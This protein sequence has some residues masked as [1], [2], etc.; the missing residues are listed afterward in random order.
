MELTYS[1]LNGEYLNWSLIN[2]D[3]RNKIDGLRF[4]QHIDNV[5]DVPHSWMVLIFYIH[6]CERVYSELLKRLYELEYEK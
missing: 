2:G 4:A 5:Y 6:S 3:G 1:K